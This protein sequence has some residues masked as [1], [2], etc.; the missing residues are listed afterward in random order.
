MTKYDSNLITIN[1]VETAINLA[2]T[3]DLLDY[4]DGI[5][6]WDCPEAEPVAQELCDRFNVNFDA[7]DG[8]DQ[9]FDALVKLGNGA[10]PV[11]YFLQ[12]ADH[13]CD[14]DTAYEYEVY[15][16]RDHEIDTMETFVSEDEAR[17]SLAKYGSEILDYGRY[18]LVRMYFINAHDLRDDTWDIIDVAEMTRQE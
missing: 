13:E 2:E 3:K 1:G 9:L 10:A 16:Y 6:S 8:Y 18:Y 7:Y 15:D 17:K 14:R 5:P 11:Q 4:L 12:Y